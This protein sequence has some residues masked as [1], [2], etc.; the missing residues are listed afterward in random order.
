MLVGDVVFRVRT[1]ELGVRYSLTDY[2]H[3]TPL[4]SIFILETEEEELEYMSAEGLFR[5]E[6]TLGVALANLVL[7]MASLN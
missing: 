2:R 1:T 6:C 7:R 3:P 4:E 5:I